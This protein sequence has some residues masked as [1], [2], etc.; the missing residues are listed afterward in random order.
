MTGTKGREYRDLELETSNHLMRHDSR[1]GLGR[2]EEAAYHALQAGL[3]RVRMGQFCW[4]AEEYTQAVE[5]W[6]S[7][8]GC[9][10]LATACRQ[11]TESLNHL[12]R[13][14]AEGKI[15]ARRLDLHAA[16]RE[17]DQGLKD[18]MQRVQQFGRD[19]M[20]QGHRLEVP[21]DRTLRFLQRSVR[22][23]PG[24][25]WLHYAIFRQAAGLGQQELADKHLAW[26]AAFDPEDAAHYVAL[27]GYR[28]IARGKPDRALALGNDFLAAHC[29]NTGQVRIMLANALGSDS[30]VRP[31]DQE[32]AI[33]V[34]RPLVEDAGADPRQRI[35]ALALSAT[36]QHELGHAQVFESLVQEFNHLEGSL[37]DPELTKD[38]AQLRGLIPHPEVNGSGEVP[39]GPLRL[40]PESDR[41]QLFQKAKE[42]SVRLEAVPA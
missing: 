14:E 35:A 37:D 3:G 24:Y 30:R 6:L 11:A 40:L 36:F 31:P 21:D 4:D 22:D 7:A 12:H 18:L 19:V 39:P 9:F 13:L 29:E 20:V 28:Q 32:R 23:L 16:L 27:L 25:S 10:V 8:A 26:A 1:R 41:Y 38:L 2:Y 42:V 15:P 34:L 33:E 17:H 5:D